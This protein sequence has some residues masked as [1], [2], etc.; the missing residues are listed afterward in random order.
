MERRWFVLEGDDGGTVF[1]TIP[2]ELVPVPGARLRVRNAL[3]FLNHMVWGNQRNMTRL[4]IFQEFEATEEMHP[5][6]GGP[7]Y[8]AYLV[9]EQAAHERLARAEALAPHGVQLCNT[10]LQGHRVWQEE[11]S[12]LRE[13]RV[14]GRSPTC[15]HG[16][17]L[18]GDV[19][20]KP[21]FLVDGLETVN[22]V[23]RILG[24]P[25]LREFNVVWSEEER[26]RAA[27]RNQPVGGH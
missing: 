21:C 13:W 10:L 5:H 24:I 12:Y 19:W 27:Y 3:A 9:R 7:A 25:E 2:V 22:R 17:L 4:R 20:L 11:D 23:R 18:D 1:A 16:Y 14:V 6:W 26:R 15:M 8:E